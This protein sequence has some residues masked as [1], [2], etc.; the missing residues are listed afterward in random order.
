MST[1]QNT[2][3]S[4]CRH[5]D[6]N[7]EDCRGEVLRVLES[8]VGTEWENEVYAVHWLNGD[9]SVQVDRQGRN[10][11]MLTAAEARQLAAALNASADTMEMTADE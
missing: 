5:A 2:C 3:T 10:I 4:W 9:E 8:L 6:P 7:H 11:L 1:P